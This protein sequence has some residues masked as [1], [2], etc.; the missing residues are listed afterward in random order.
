MNMI[1]QYVKIFI[2]R[3]GDNINKIKHRRDNFIK[4][5]KCNHSM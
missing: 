2:M 5:E 1:I 3:R 4:N